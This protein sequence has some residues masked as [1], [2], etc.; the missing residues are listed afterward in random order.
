LADACLLIENENYHFSFKIDA[1]TCKT[2]KAL[3]TFRTLADQTNAASEN[4][5]ML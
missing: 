3:A 1:Q 2:S 4:E 5:N